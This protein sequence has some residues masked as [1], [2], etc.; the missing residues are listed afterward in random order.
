VNAQQI[1][2]SVLVANPGCYPTASILALLPALQHGFIA[3]SGIVITALSGVTGAG[4]TSSFD[5]SFSE[6]NENVRAYK[7]GVHQHLPEITGIL[8]R[9]TGRRTSLSFVPHLIPCSRGIYTTIHAPLQQSVSEE[10]L[11]QCYED[12]YAEARFVRVR[13][14]I[15]QLRDVIRT[16]YCDIGFRIDRATQQLVLISVIDN[17]VKGAAGQAMQNMNIMFQCPQDRGLQ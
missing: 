7:I 12:Y 5:F 1:A 14:D 11:F 17:L 8:G 10:D 3:S 6:V 13:R 16:N 9:V 15:P 4:K 2:S